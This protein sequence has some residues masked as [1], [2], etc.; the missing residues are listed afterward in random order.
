[1]NPIQL[2][3]KIARVLARLLYI[4]A[5]NF[6]TVTVIL[7]GLIATAIVSRMRRNKIDIGLGP[8]P[9]INNVY[10]KAALT[11]FGYSAETYVHS[12]YYITDAFDFRGDKLTG[13]RRYFM[14][15]YLF[16]RAALKY[17]AV[18]LYFNGGP[19]A[20]TRLRSLE[21]FLFRLAKVRMVVMPYG[22]DI[23]DLGRSPSLLFRHAT[24]RDYPGFKTRRSLVAQQIDYWTTNA[25]HII[26]GCD[27]VYYMHHWDTLMLAHFSIDMSKW[28]PA[29]QA[30]KPA[31]FNKSR[32]LRLFHAPN[33]TNIK[34]TRFF[35]EAVEQLKSEGMHIEL[36]LKSKVSNAEIREAMQEADVILD[37]LVVGWYAM[38]AI[39]AMAMEKPVVCYLAPD[40]IELFEFASIVQSEEIPLIRSDIHD[41]RQTLRSLYKGEL[42]LEQIGER[43][44]RYVHKYHS[45]EAVGRHF[46]AINRTLGLTPGR[47]P[48]K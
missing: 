14:P 8:E 36:T 19:L 23:Q 28:L 39:E 47:G 24:T 42:D 35:V 3:K 32:P 38:F 31:R 4:P 5:K 34:G 20:T 21:A 37:Q 27:W 43:S 2:A 46:D 9:L 7:P 48:E 17:R 16:A 25:D 10:H 13:L 29:K 45:I 15:Y 26:G 18:Y 44:R 30:K 22:S 33:H 40:L 12:V 41:I 6:F 11:L 1:M